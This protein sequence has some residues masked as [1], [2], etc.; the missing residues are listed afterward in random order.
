MKELVTI[1]LS[2]LYG[3]GVYVRHALYD[4]H[5]LPSV[6]VSVPTICVGNL[7]AGGTGKTPHVE[8]IV[9]LLI[10]HGYHVAVLSRGYKRKTRGFILADETATARTIGDEAMQLHRKFPEVAV[11][12]CENR[13]HGVKM[14]QSRVARTDVIVLDDAMQHRPLRC[15]LNILLTPYSPLYI[16]DHM[17]PWGR[18][19]DL[20]SRA[21]KADM[22]VVTKCPEGMQP[23]DMR[24][25]DNKLHLPTY[26]HL[27]FSGMQYGEL[28]AEGNPL[29]VCGIAEPAYLTEHVRQL[30]P[31]ADVMTYKDH[32]AYSKRDVEA[33]I[34]RADKYDFVLTTEKDAKRLR[35]TSL[36]QQLN[37]RGKQLIV[38]PI[39]VKMIYDG[40]HFDTQILNY[41][42]ENRRP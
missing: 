35:L 31:H 6:T 42:R 9:R 19:R 10:R 3:L 41:M 16:E 40:E 30:Y 34:A 13:V 23:I 21:L 37:A 26:Q 25:V 14:L 7:A 12:V 22:I 4:N 8:Y 24:V 2:W 27:Y 29:I 39:A 11:A 20:P 5:L 17:L 15:G 36:E 33:I 28:R 18:L 38:L 32:H 1:P